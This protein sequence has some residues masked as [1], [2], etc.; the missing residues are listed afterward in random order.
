MTADSRAA[1]W[2]VQAGRKGGRGKRREREGLLFSGSFFTLFI[3]DYGH[4]LH[5]NLTLI[6]SVSEENRDSGA[7]R[8]VCV[9][10]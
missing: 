6:Y 1:W 9:C 5:N 4:C 7:V 10:A 3:L 2:T 8:G